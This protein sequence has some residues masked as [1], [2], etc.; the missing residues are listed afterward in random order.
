MDTSESY[1]LRLSPS[2]KLTLKHVAESELFE[3]EMVGLPSSA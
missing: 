1:N 2:E 3:R